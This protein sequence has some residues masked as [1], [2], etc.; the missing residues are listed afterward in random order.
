VLGGNKTCQLINEDG[1][2]L[3]VWKDWYADSGKW[4]NVA[5]HDSLPLP[6]AGFDA[7]YGQ[8]VVHHGCLSGFPIHVRRDGNNMPVFSP[9]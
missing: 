5:G 6:Q 9:Q 1:Q 2:P 4:K 7:A 3:T 8:H